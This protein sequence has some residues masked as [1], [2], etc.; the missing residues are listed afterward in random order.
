[1]SEENNP[2]TLGFGVG[3]GMG[4]GLGILTALIADISI[5]IGITNGVATGII[6]G[7]ITGLSLE[8]HWI[9]KDERMVIVFG[10]GWGTLVGIGQG[11]LTAWT[12]NFS[13][14]SGFST[15][16]IAG[17]TLGTILGMQIFLF[18][19]ND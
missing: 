19:K 18:S 5:I 1:M 2:G 4:A 11:L 17:L 16:S 14:V 12:H 10:M 8:R 9:G 3:I 7:G 6:V 13:Y 15:G